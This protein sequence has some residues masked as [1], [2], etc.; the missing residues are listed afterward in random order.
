MRG[1]ARSLLISLLVSLA[2]AS[3]AAADPD[4]LWKIINQCVVATAPCAKVDAANHYALL[5]DRNGVAQHLLI[6]TDKV[7]GIESPALVD[8]A[9]PNYFAAAWNEHSAVDALL[10]QPLPRDGISLAV[11]AQNARSQ[12]QLHIHIDCLS[13]EA[14][15]AFKAAAPSVGRQWQPLAQPIAG[16]SFQAIRVDGDTLDGFN[17]FLALAKA[18][19]DPATEMAGHNLVVVGETFAEG[20]G[21]LVLSDVAPAAGAWHAGGEDVQDHTCAIDR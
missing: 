3:P 1:S 19:A 20:P 18:L 8:P 17:P 21:F 9:T 2:S 10:P 15:D 6:P 13:P 4:A 16:H 11:N 5:K 12:N 7:T 14:R